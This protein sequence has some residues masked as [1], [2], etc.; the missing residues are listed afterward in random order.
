MRRPP[1]PLALASWARCLAR[2]CLCQG[3]AIP[4]SRALSWTEDA[5]RLSTTEARNGETFLRTRF[6]KN[7]W[8]IL[9]RRAND[10][11]RYRF[12][13]RLSLQQVSTSRWPVG[14]MLPCRW[15]WRPVLPTSGI[16]RLRLGSA[17]PLSHSLYALIARKVRRNWP[18]L[19][20]KGFVPRA[21]CEYNKKGG[22]NC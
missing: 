3:N 4:I 19:L 15:G 21:P 16:R 7:G 11:I 20:E 5:V 13:L 12:G 17:L 22:S 2:T 14:A 10:L 6:R 9:F 8:A 1:I 18:K